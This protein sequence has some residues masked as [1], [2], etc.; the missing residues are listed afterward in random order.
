MVHRCQHCSRAMLT[1]WMDHSA[2]LVLQG[3]STGCAACTIDLP[4]FY[5]VAL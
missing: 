1:L 4:A 3:A 5:T 2:G